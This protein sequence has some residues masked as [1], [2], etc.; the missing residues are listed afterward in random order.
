MFCY[1]MSTSNNKIVIR[2]FSGI[3]WLYSF[4]NSS[5]SILF[6]VQYLISL[7]YLSKTNLDFDILH[8]IYNL[9]KL[10]NTNNIY[11]LFPNKTVSVVNNNLYLLGIQITRLAQEDKNI[12][13]NS[14]YV[15][16]LLYFGP[17]LK[18]TCKSGHYHSEIT[19]VR[20]VHYNH[21]IVSF[22]GVSSSDSLTSELRTV[23][24]GYTTDLTKY[25]GLS[26]LTDANGDVIKDVFVI[27]SFIPF[28]THDSTDDCVDAT[29][30]TILTQYIQNETECM[31]CGYSSGAAKALI[32][33][34]L[35]AGKYPNMQFKVY[36]YALLKVYSNRIA[37]L[38]DALPNLDVYVFNDTRDPVVSCYNIL[39]MTNC[40]RY[41][42]LYEDEDPL[43]V[44]P[45][46]NELGLTSTKHVTKNTFNLAYINNHLPTHI[47]ALV[48]KYN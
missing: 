25:P 31:F 36:V 37:D 38:I 40:D 24:S 4:F 47:A 11:D 12:V 5:G 10:I 20:A 30:D 17:Y 22:P 15:D 41:S 32:K 7:A 18:K 21:L 45:Y 48:D 8:N 44:I 26:G 19:V 14:R 1:L 28:I 33:G 23:F 35:Y 6:H 9:R 3:P 43:F 34:I 27:R 29:E 39:Q 16:T 2:Q 13:K 42:P 46:Q